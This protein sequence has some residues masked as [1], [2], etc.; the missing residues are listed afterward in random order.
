MLLLVARIDV[1]DPPTESGGA[2][3]PP[4]KVAGLGD[5]PV[6]SGGPE[7]RPIKVAGPRYIPLI[8]VHW[9]VSTFGQLLTLL[10]I[11]CLQL[12]SL[13]PNVWCMI[14]QMYFLVLN[15]ILVVQI[16][17]HTVL[18]GVMRGHSRSN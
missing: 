15:L 7:T 16:S 6:Q 14:M 8:L 2:Q 11:H 5:P 9:T 3:D 1:S 13:L 10:L 4:V 12:S 17:S 18:T